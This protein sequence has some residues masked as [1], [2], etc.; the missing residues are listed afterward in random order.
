[1]KNTYRE[2]RNLKALKNRFAIL[3]GLEKRKLSGQRG[4][5]KG[6]SEQALDTLLS[7]RGRD[8]KE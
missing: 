7:R 6:K 1:M 2:Q 5:Q 8:E 3:K 4:A